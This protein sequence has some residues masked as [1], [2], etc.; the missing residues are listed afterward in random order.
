[1]FQSFFKTT[2]SSPLSASCLDD[3]SDDYPVQIPFPSF[4]L[5]EQDIIS[6]I[7]DMKS[8]S[9]CLKTNIPALV[10]KKCKLSLATPLKLF[11]EKSLNT[12]KIPSSYKSQTIIPIHKKGSKLKA[13]NFRP[14]VLTPHEIKIIERVLRK[15]IYSHLEN[16]KLININQHGFR[17]N[18]S[19]T[20]QLL[21]HSHFILSNCIIGNEVDSVY[22]DYAK[23]FDKV[24]HGILLKKLH[25]Y[26]IPNIY[27]NWI[28]NFLSDRFQ[29][30][31][32]GNC[33]SYA[34]PVIML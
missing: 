17:Q 16:N 15:L 23:A 1:M 27:L 28:T 34:T 10:F 32:V 33:Y 19:C 13:N 24:D 25:N 26:K 29:K 6:A 22:L 18:H 7:N 31:L 4:Q 14:I 30:V 3:F 8:T 2:F 21:A 9:S 12:G 11:W 20:T 5:S